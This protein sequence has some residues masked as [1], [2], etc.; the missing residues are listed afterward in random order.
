MLKVNV[1]KYELRYRASYT[2]RIHCDE[3][4]RLLD[5]RLSGS[6]NRR[7]KET[8]YILPKLGVGRYG[9]RIQVKQKTFSSQKLSA[10]LGSIQPPFKGVSR[11]FPRD[12]GEGG[13]AG[14]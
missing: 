14:T 2:R 6:S 9:V 7:Q 11:F 8:S 1:D 10:S 5:K 3:I 4:G 13:A 12:G